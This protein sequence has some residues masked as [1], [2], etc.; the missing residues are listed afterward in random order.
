MVCLHLNASTVLSCD[1]FRD[2][3]SK[4]SLLSTDQFQEKFGPAFQM[5]ERAAILLASLMKTFQS[6]FRFKEGRCRCQLLHLLKLK[7]L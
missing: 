5:E 7:N 4:F 2:K 1:Q 3:R 6:S